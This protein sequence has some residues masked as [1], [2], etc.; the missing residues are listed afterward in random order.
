[1]GKATKKRAILKDEI[2]KLIEFDVSNITTYYTPYLKLSKDIFIFSY[3]GCGIN[4]TDIANLT[5]GNIV[6]DRIFYERQKTGKQINFQLQPLAL[7]LI[8]KYR[9]LNSKE[10]DYIFPIL[11]KR[12]HITEQQKYD[13]IHKSIGGV[14]KT[15]KRIGELAGL[16]IPLTTYV[17]RHTFATVLK[18]SGV[19]TGIISESLGHSSEKVTQVYLDC[20]ENSQIDEAMKSL[21]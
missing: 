11:N 1:M 5:Y 19:N 2:K 15:L 20:F 3:L 9:G 14:N 4:F 6:Q 12:I 7:S 13:R 10:D 16:S 8:E 17:A 18:R 21:L